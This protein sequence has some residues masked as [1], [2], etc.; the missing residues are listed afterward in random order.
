MFDPAPSLSRRHTFPRRGAHHSLDAR[1]FV[2]D[3]SAPRGLLP[4]LASRRA[5]PPNA[6]DAKQRSNLSDLFLNSLPLMIE[7]F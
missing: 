6:A 5:S 7:P 2:L 3:A 1:A 4:I